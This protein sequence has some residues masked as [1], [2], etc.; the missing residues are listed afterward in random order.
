MSQKNAILAALK[1][2]RRLTSLDALSDFN[3][4]RLGARIWDLRQLGHDAQSE[5]V[6]MA[7]GKRVARYWLSLP[8]CQQ[9]LSLETLDNDPI[10]V[11]N[12]CR[13]SERRALT[14]PQRGRR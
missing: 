14:T 1:A 8:V 9:S 6:E 3:C 10:L 7:T 2:G 12:I 11:Y 4:L 13:Q 5:M